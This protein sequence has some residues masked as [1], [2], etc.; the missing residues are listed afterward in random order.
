MSQLEI[1]LATIHRKDY[2]FLSSMNI[3]TDIVVANQANENSINFISS[4]NGTV[5]LITTT[6]RGVG[7]NRN[8][9]LT[10]SSA[11]FVLFSDD[12]IFY[13]NNYEQIIVD[14]FRKIPEADILIFECSEKG[15]SRAENRKIKKISKV[16]LWNFSRYGT[17][18]IAMRRSSWVRKN[19]YF[20]E[21]FGGGAM[22][23]SGE[24]T[25][26]L[27]QCLKQHLKIFTYPACIAE[28]DQ[29]A[30]TWFDGY[31]EKFFFDKGALL[32]AAFPIAHHILMWYF[33]I[34]FKRFSKLSYFQ[35]IQLM[36]DGTAAEKNSRGYREDE[37]IN[38]C[39]SS[40]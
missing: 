26:F 38:N 15:C 10:F 12:D 29:S 35:C 30:S 32:K 2:T 21:R 36:K 34:K 4:K 25:L 3:Q 33:L 23:G 6:T 7:K 22:Y 17:Y 27:R 20:S 40:V 28:V 16:H 37:N 19:I 5:K 1:L 18:R 9:A 13:V 8:I 39:H 24:D 31:N 11:P 14:A